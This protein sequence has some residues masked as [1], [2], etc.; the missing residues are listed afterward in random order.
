MFQ[1]KFIEEIKTHISF[2]ITFLSENREIMWKIMEET[3]RP[4]MTIW[5]M[6]IA[7]WIPK[8]TNAHISKCNTYSF[9]TESMDAR[10]SFSVT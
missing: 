10:T 5:Y 3:V 9:S 6:R 1:T 8:T 4:Q 7:F 2:S